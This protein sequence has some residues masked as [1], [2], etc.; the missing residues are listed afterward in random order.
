MTKAELAHLVLTEKELNRIDY[1]LP[2]RFVEDCRNLLNIDVTPFMVWI[3][4]DQAPIGGRPLNLAERF[5]QIYNNA[6][7]LWNNTQALL[8]DAQD[9]GDCYDDDGEMHRD[10]LRVAHSL[11]Q[12]TLDKRE[13]FGEKLKVDGQ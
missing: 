9:R 13:I 11:D 7:N 12:I 4:D 10:Y 5:Y 1:A 8:I 3:Y 2:Q 6:Q